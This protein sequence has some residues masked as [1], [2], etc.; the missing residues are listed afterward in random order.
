[1][2]FAPLR[3]LQALLPPPRWQLPV[4]ALLGIVVGVGAVIFHM[5]RATS[6]LSDDPGACINCHIMM[7]Q[8]TT[9]RHSSHARVAHCNDCHVP[10]TSLAA[11]YFFKAKDG[12]RH[13]TLFTLGMEQQVIRATPASR[14]VVQQNCLRCHG[15]L[16]A[17][18]STG[19]SNPHASM[20]AEGRMCWDCH[21]EVPHGRVRSLSSVP[22]ARIQLEASE[23][24]EWMHT[25]KPQSDGDA[26]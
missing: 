12:S 25:K 1:M 15:D 21:R 8:Y 24:P 6:Y 13:A 11:K 19:S 16:N 17:D 22:N 3:F 14:E 10:H 18:V 2:A 4:L 26:R 23:L 5:S 9:W 20:T 7:P